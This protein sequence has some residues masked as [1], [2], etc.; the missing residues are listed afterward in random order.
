MSANDSIFNQ[1]A[2]IG[3]ITPEVAASNL[4]SVG[5]PLEVPFVAPPNTVPRG[6]ENLANTGPVARLAQMAG[7]TEKL[8]DSSIKRMQEGNKAKK[9]LQDAAEWSA[10]LIEGTKIASKS[11]DSMTALTQI[12]ALP[13]HKNQWF[14]MG[15][16]SVVIGEH[17]SRYRNDLVKE[18]LA[19][20]LATPEEI[21]DK[22]KGQYAEGLSG[23]NPAL[24]GEYFFKTAT[25]ADDD[26]RKLYD[27]YQSENFTNTIGAAVGADLYNVF[28]SE[29]AL[30]NS[31]NK[32]FDAAR[33]VIQSSIQSVMEKHLATGMP[34]APVVE[35]AIR[36]ATSIASQQEGLTKKWAVLDSLKDIKSPT[37]APILSNPEVAEKF[38]KSRRELAELANTEENVRVNE[39]K[40]ASTRA[41]AAYVKWLGE[42]KAAGKP[43]PSERDAT[44]KAI[45]LNMD[46]EDAQKIL[47]SFSSEET[48]TGAK[49]YGNNFKSTILKNLSSPTPNHAL[50]RQQALDAYDQKKISFEDFNWTNGKIDSDEE[51]RKSTASWG[52]VEKSGYRDAIKRANLTVTN[53]YLKTRLAGVGDGRYDTEDEVRKAILDSVGIEMRDEL[54]PV[55]QQN[56][57]PNAV[58]AE[59]QQLAPKYIEE[60]E[61]RWSLVNKYPDHAREIIVNGSLSVETE[62]RET[63]KKYSQK[64]I[65]Q[66]SSPVRQPQRQQQPKQ[67]QAAQ[68]KP[69]DGYWGLSPM[70]R[71]NKHARFKRGPEYKKWKST[72]MRGNDK[73]KPLTQ[74]QVDKSFKRG[75]LW[76][77]M[78]TQP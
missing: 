62:K 26:D 8:F 70:E 60:V 58:V 6:F 49:E 19:N 63:L 54:L 25:A 2:R 27:K 68:S 14:R 66:T 4:P 41:K 73:H 38:M 74:E 33:P 12:G 48:P 7:M 72:L 35:N 61:R 67:P 30:V 21:Q 65:P 24:A 55:A 3:R 10:G 1:F 5:V 69:S 59:A 15:V 29:M 43:L 39:E 13:A 50:L 71:Y 56:G 16:E 34:Y 22:L 20:P 36:T 76:A 44:K 32:T 47:G 9:Q 78:K 75:G 42:T 57:D 11:R 18:R 53:P 28:D 45:E 17:A 51:G 52:V 23:F 37:G 77:W 64:T 46:P 40:T 31:G